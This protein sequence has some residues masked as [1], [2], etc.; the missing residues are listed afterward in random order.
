L[1][2]LA[3]AGFAQAQSTNGGTAEIQA[4]SGPV[5]VNWGQPATLPNADQYQVQIADLDSNHDGKISRS[6]A[7]PNGALSSEFKLVDKNH[8][9]FITAAELANWH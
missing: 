2:A 7:A 4:K 3:V 5:T 6:E 1:S 8:D 9:G